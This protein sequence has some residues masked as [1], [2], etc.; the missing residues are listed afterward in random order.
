M[1]YTFKDGT[2]REANLEEIAQGEE[3]VGFLTAEELQEEGVRLGLPGAVIEECGR[4]QTQFRNSIE[5]YDAVSFGMIHAMDVRSVRSPRDRIAFF[6]TEK[7]FLL[8]PLVDEDESTRRLFLEVLDRS[9]HM[10]TRE[11][12][13]CGV[14]DGLLRGAGEALEA[15]GEE[16]LA[17]ERQLAE[18]RQNQSLNRR[19]FHMKNRMTIQ[20]AYYEQLADIGTELQENAN[21]LF[22]G[23]DLRYFKVFSDKAQRLSAHTS[24]ISESLIHLKEALDAAQD[25]YL[26][27]IMKLF[28]VVTTVFLPL[29]LI[30]GWY[31]MNFANMPEL[32]WKYG[33]VCV[34]AVS[35][36]VAAGCLILFK[37]KK[38]L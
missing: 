26:N 38:L 34:I 37:K 36:L 22:P 24:E 11:K 35:I 7:L 20:R 9:R 29:S 17:M 19:I 32:T 2:W 13:A 30:V 10:P 25:Y 1:L 4:G 14:L 23:E 33:Y 15:E 6:V 21:S 3:G 8:V 5:I 28:T 16:L 18:G 12:I 31:G 27:S